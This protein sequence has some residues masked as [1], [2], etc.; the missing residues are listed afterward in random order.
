MA[1]QI[2][3]VASEVRRPVQLPEHNVEADEYMVNDYLFT[4]D[5]RWE[6]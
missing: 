3:G 5:P 2:S 6:S 4:S 1:C